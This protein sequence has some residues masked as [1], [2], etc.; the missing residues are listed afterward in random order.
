[1]AAAEAECENPLEGLIDTT[2]I[3]FQ[4]RMNG[5]DWPAKLVGVFVW[6]WSAVT[7]GSE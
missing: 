5:D 1:M 3:P 6:R 2:P 7:E 4:G